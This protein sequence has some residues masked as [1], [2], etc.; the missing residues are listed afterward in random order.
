MAL[1]RC[2]LGFQALD[3]ETTPPAQW[4][5]LVVGMVWGE[6][7]ALEIGYNV[8]QGHPNGVEMFRTNLSWRL[9]LGLEVTR[10]IGVGAQWGL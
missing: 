6:V 2:Q 3:R 1:P 8:P 10:G 7:H 5:A 4:A 9:E